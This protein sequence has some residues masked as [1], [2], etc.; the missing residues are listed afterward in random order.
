MK[1]KNRNQILL[2]ILAKILVKSCC[3]KTVTK[4]PKRKKTLLKR[5]QR[6]SRE[7]NNKIIEVK[8]CWI[9]PGVTETRLTLLPDTV[10]K[11]GR[12][13]RHWT[14]GDEGQEKR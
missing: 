9:L 4:E 10:T 5:N 13:G 14:S 11:E 7:I 1:T 12:Q 6:D 8:V 3:E 2:I